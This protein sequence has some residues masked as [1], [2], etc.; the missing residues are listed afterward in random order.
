MMR[1]LR[2][3]AISILALAVLVLGFVAVANALDWTGTTR[4]IVGGLGLA[5]FVVLAGSLLFLAAERRRLKAM[6]APPPGQ[7]KLSYTTEASVVA[8]RP[9][10][11]I[12]GHPRGNGSGNV[13][14]RR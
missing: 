6:A 3:E 1:S 8:S 10:G 11:S 2:T 12:A 13:S 14:T 5:L 7:L 9:R 4:L